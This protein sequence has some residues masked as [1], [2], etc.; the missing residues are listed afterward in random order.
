MVS[1]GRRQMVEGSTAGRRRRA[2][3]HEHE[4]RGHHRRPRR[5]RRRRG[6]HAVDLERDAARRRPGSR[7]GAP[8]GLRDPGCGTWVPVRAA[9]RASPAARPRATAYTCTSA[10]PSPGWPRGTR[11]APRRNCAVGDHDAGGGPV[12]D[13]PV[14]DLDPDAPATACGAPTR[15]GRGADDDHV[16]RDGVGGRRRRRRRAASHGRSSSGAPPAAGAVRQADRAGEVGVGG[17]AR[18]RR[19]SPGWR[20]DRARRGRRRRPSTRDVGRTGGGSPHGSPLRTGLTD[21]LT[22]VRRAA[23]A[24]TLDAATTPRW[25]ASAASR[26]RA[27]GVLGSGRRRRP[28][29]AGRCTA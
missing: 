16:H 12:V 20:G 10:R 25:H 17:R 2:S 9:G 11:S 23:A 29:A 5:G 4:G 7:S 22:A 27:A 1:A 14:V 6:G 26:A 24:A 28:G 13:D 3:D 15:V 18:T 8:R 21:A 19:A